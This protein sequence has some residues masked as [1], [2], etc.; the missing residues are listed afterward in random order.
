MALRILGAYRS[1]AS[2]YYRVIAPFSV[3]RYRTEHTFDVRQPGIKDAEEYDVL[4]L[5]QHADPTAEL[6]AREFKE[7]GRLVVY[8]VDDWL[9]GL[10][11]SW[12][13]YDHYF[14]RGSGQ[15]T[16]RLLFHERLLDLADV[17]TT[18]TDYLAG[19]LRDRFRGKCVEVLP[20]CIVQ[21]EWDTIPDTGNTLD[22]PVLGW[23][24]TENHWD[25]WYEIAPAVDEAL[26]A[27]G[28]HLA[29]IGAPELVAG[30]PERLAART[31]VFPLVPFHQFNQVRRLIKAFDVGLAW[32]T[33][34]T[35]AS[36]CRSPLKA[37]QYGAAGV[38]VVASAM[39][40]ADL[41]VRY[42]DVFAR[43]VW[44]AGD[45]LVYALIQALSDGPEMGR[46]PV[47][48]WREE[49]WQNHSYERQA[50]RWLELLLEVLDGSS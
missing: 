30:F 28:G 7:R 6:V 45:E 11:P 8:D 39:V 33:G 46:E 23:F 47:A 50:M 2:G 41:Y 24:G 49:V 43:V 12:P 44:D 29:L 9:F 17:V 19:K 36:K 18:T 32:C 37:I 22:G 38:P 35:E 1:G 42:E 14:E 21:G 10:P 25:D 13:C 40:Y 16:Q 31:Q 15:P 5:H 27:V 48:K 20:N 3:L 4:W 26:E 34:R